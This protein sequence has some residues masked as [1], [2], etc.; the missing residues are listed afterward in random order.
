MKGLASTPTK[1]LQVGSRLKCIDNTGA[2]EIQ[3]ISVLVYKGVRK[4]R[5]KAGV[6]D[7][8]ICSVKKGDQKI[9]H[10]VV[11]AV[12]VRQRALWR[13][14]SGIRIAFTDNA[15][16][17]VDENFEPRGKEIKGAIAK[18]VIERYARIGKI[19]SAVV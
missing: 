3:V 9:M 19:A 11:K 14:S 2:K 17:L 5:A 13:R 4:R 15:A 18:E 10:E 6:G 7:V 16:I 8:V 1:G 12:V